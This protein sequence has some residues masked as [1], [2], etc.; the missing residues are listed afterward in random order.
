MSFSM[1]QRG[2]PQKHYDMV[3]KCGKYTTIWNNGYSK[4]SFSRRLYQRGVS[5]LPQI[6][7]KLRIDVLTELGY[8]SKCKNLKRSMS[9][10]Y[11]ITLVE[12]IF[13]STIQY[14]QCHW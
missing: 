5:V 4:R 12:T 2:V 3:W 11:E 8:H 9:N 6:W 14:A 7:D 1:W 13:N 10:Y